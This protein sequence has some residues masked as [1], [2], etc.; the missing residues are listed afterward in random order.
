[1]RQVGRTLTAADE[2]IPGGRRVLICDR[3]AKRSAPAREQLGK[4]GIR[5]VQ[6]PCQAPDAKGR[7]P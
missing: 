3:D 6:T 4:A 7:M 1:M 2:G 5:V